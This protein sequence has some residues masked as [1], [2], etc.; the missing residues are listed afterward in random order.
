MVD[1]AFQR[2]KPRNAG[3]NFLE[4]GLPV[5]GVLLLLLIAAGSRGRELIGLAVKSVDVEEDGVA[6]VAPWRIDADPFA[7]TGDDRVVGDTVQ[8]RQVSARARDPR[9]PWRHFSVSGGGERKKKDENER[10]KR[11]RRT[12]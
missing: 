3:C 12:I 2:H 10:R 1:I 6:N 9:G 7:Q 4:T 5:C 11:M 8:R